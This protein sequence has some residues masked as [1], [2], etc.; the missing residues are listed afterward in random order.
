M[1]PKTNSK[2]KNEHVKRTKM[3]RPTPYSKIEDFGREI[4][5]HKWT[6]V[7]E[8]E[9]VDD[10]VENFHSYMLGLLNTHFP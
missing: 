7:L 10:K 6:E 2:Y 5:S 8:A 4:T 1:A 3:V 9:N